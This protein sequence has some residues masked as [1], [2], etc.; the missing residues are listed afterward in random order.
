MPDA[1]VIR[2]GMLVV[3]APDHDLVSPLGAILATRPARNQMV[4]NASSDLVT[5]NC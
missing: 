4:S 2:G 3:A 1:A 5:S